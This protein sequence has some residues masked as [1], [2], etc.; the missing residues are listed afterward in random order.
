MDAIASRATTRPPTRVRA[1][2]ASRFSVMRCV[3][4]DR[5]RRRRRLLCFV[6]THRRRRPP[7]RPRRRIA[8][9]RRPVVYGDVSGSAGPVEKIAASGRWVPEFLSLPVAVDN[10]PQE[11][12]LQHPAIGT[13]VL[14]AEQIDLD[15]G[16][17]RPGLGGQAQPPTR[18]RGCARLGRGHRS[19]PRSSIPRCAQQVV[20]TIDLNDIDAAGDR[21]KV[22]RVNGIVDTELYPQ[23]RARW[24]RCS[25]PST[26]R[27]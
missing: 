14:M 13:L 16:Q 9:Q 27:M 6:D 23:R 22:L 15:A 4:G 7:L 8:A 18:R 20:G 26:R 24:W 3:I 17:R 12:D 10:K 11:P 19:R 5:D 2:A 21:A 1:A 25:R